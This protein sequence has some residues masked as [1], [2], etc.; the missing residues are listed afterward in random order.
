[1]SLKANILIQGQTDAGLYREHNEDTIGHDRN[2]ALAVLADGMGGHRSGEIASAITVS[3]VLELARLEPARPESTR[4]KTISNIAEIGGD[5]SKTGLML[6]HAITQANKKVY[7]ASQLN[8][9]YSGMGTTVVAILFYDNHIHI[10]HVGDSR[11][12]RLRND[13]LNQITRDHSYVQEMLDS[14]VYTQEQAKNSDRKNIITRAI[15]INEKVQIDMQQEKV[16]TGD[17]YLLCSDGVNDMID[18]ETIKKILSAHTDDLDKAAYELIHAANKHG[19][20]DNI[21]AL[22]SKVV[23]PFPA[24]TSWFS[25]LSSFFK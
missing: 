15:G 2:I 3:T 8:S 9:Q 23:K 10:A 13:Q 1:M 14:G 22:L 17:I 25:R 16:E 19:G 18:D 6:K 12:Y 11:L 4:I 24:Q 7:E 5:Y 20:K 21:S